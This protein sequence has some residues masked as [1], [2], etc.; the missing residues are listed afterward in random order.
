MTMRRELLCATDVFCSRIGE[1]EYSYKRIQ[2]VAL[3][4]EYVQETVKSWQFLSFDSC[5]IKKLDTSFLRFAVE[6]VNL[7]HDVVFQS[8]LKATKGSHWS[9]LSWPVL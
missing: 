9:N 8:I 2:E 4:H 5:E 7:G 6:D 3:Q 1:V